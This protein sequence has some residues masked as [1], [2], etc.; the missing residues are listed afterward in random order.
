VLYSDKDGQLTCQM[1]RKDC[2]AETAN[3]RGRST[4]I[5]DE[6]DRSIRRKGHKR[7]QLLGW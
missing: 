1:V 2:R 5:Y 4:A 3:E 7:C 6:I